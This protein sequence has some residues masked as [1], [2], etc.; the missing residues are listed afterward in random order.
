MLGWPGLPEP[1]HILLEH[2]HRLYSSN[3]SLSVFI[4]LGGWGL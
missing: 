4:F 1:L 3:T 2:L